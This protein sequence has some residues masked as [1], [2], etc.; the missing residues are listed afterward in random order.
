MKSIVLLAA[1]ALV[2]GLA[3]AATALDRS[4]D[5]RTGRIKAEVVVE[6]LEHPWGLA[7]LPN[8]AILVTER[9]GRLR[10]ISPKGALSEP[11][12]G[13]P[14][15]FAQGQG[16]LLDVA[17]D[18]A[19]ADNQLVYLS[20]AEAGE[21]GAS[22]A[23]ARGRL[24]GDELKDVEVIF[25]Q[26]PKVAGPNHF[27]SRLVFGRDGT[28]FV[29]LGERFKFDPAQDLSSDLGKVVRI[30]ADGSIP[31]DNPFVG[32]AD[33]LPEIW[34]YGHRNIQGAALHPE[35]GLLWVA[36]HG[37]KGG[38]EI[39][40]LRPG[41]NYG[42]PLVSWGR[43][44]SGEDIPDPTTRPDLADAIYQWT[45]VIAASGA[46]FYTGEQIPSWRGNLLVGGLVSKGIVRLVLDGEK[47]LDEERIPL[48]ARIR[49]VRQGPDGAVYVLT[50][51]D[52]GEIL[53]LSPAG[54]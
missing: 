53:R 10:A 12:K 15:V 54:Q 25:R 30:N 41:Q 34:S 13:V 14:K 48:A 50:D 17:L 28:L 20:Y 23:A 32:R 46:T 9:P 47:V 36:E 45:P 8:G 24:K 52:D 26:R 2:A 18:P 49:A 16:G 38:D 7:F 22:T 21:G 29:T 31:A 4:F 51:A 11:I 27:G 6:G 1:T 40:V 39:N 35:S 19:F 33:A 37:P 44:Y 43:H 5:T 42:W 3:T